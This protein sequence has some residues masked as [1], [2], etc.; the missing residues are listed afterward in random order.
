MTDASRAAAESVPERTDWAAFEHALG[1]ADDIAA[2]LDQLLDADP[3]VRATGIR[4]LERVNRQNSVDSAT[5]PVARYIVAML[6][7]PRTAAPITV[8][9]RADADSRPLRSVLLD[10]L[11]DLADDV[12]D[13]VA[14]SARE[15]GI[16][17]DVDPEVIAVRAERPAIFG[18]VAVF[19]DDD[20]PTVR[21]SA[22]TTAAQLLDD[23]ELREYRTGL[24]TPLR[25]LLA[26]SSS[27][28]HRVR[29]QRSLTARQEN[30]V[31][32]AWSVRSPGSATA[33]RWLF[34]TG[35][36]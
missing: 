22:V 27:R 7:G 13:D 17:L 10:W 16:H 3:V 2:V 1:P 35:L 19:L 6:P 5:A 32:P 8:A 23:P 34:D 33:C 11:G 28:Y 26:T 20:D 24:I 29:A 9:D 12:G 36:L 15:R 25:D 14:A 4:H 30:P 18:A 31:T 21:H